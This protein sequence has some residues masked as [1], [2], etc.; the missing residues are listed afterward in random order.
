MR[1]VKMEREKIEE[2]VESFN[3]YRSPQATAQLVK[4][5]GNAFTVLFTGSFCL[6][7]GVEDYFDDL[8]YEFD[9]LHED[10]VIHEMKQIDDFA[11]LVEYN[12][13]Q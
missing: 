5:E 11:F 7:C 10:L 12:R 8:R 2:A 9:D 3:R 1:I 6:S 4:M 13:T